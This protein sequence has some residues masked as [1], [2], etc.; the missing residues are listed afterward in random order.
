MSLLN[1]YR[2]KRDALRALQEE[3]A[4]LE[5]DEKLKKEIAFEEKLRAL[6]NEFGKTVKDVVELLDPNAGSTRKRSAAPAGKGRAMKRYVNPHTKEVV[7]TKGGNHKVLKVWRE[8]WG[9]AAVD[10]WLEA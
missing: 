2:N 1:D 5:S 7:E 10:S 6:L 3:L 9:A 8:K 4:K